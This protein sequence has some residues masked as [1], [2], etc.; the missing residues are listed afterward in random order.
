MTQRDDW[1][2]YSS[3]VR[4]IASPFVRFVLVTFAVVC[5]IL[6]IVGIFI[7][8][9]PTTPFLLLAAACYARSSVRFYNSLMN[10]RRLG[11]PLRDWKENRSISRKNK[12]IAVSLIAITLV[13]S[14]LLWIPILAVKIGLSVIGVSVSLFLLTRSE[15]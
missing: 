7:P 4:L 8:L 13:P 3:E 11:P 2:D 9:L 12:I 14:I 5:L 6:G 10:H 1:I 15:R